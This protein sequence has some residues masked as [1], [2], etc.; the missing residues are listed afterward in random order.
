MSARLREQYNTKFRDELK[1]ELG[2]TNVMAVP[3]IKK[4]VI[5]SGVGEATTNK[6]AL[7]E[8]AEIITRIAGQKPVINKAKKAIAAFKVREG[9][10]VGVSVILRGDR[11]WEFLDKLINVVFPRTKDFRGVNP[12]AFDGAGNYSLGIIDHTVFPE[13]DSNKVQKIR[14]L[15]VTIVTDARNNDKAFAL[16]NKFGFPF[17]KNVNKS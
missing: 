10:D 3:S 8:V 7:A 12:K 16:L 17:T 14:P 11:M 15:Q 9:M 4:I 5:N 1:A 6:E 13:I 2:L